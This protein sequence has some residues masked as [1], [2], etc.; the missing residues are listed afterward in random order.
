MP[1]DNPSDTS[2]SRVNDSSDQASSVP[3]DFESQERF[4]YILPLLKNASEY[5]VPQNFT[6]TVMG[7]LAAPKRLNPLARMRERFGNINIRVWTDVADA[8]ECALCFFLAGF[9]YFT[10]SIVLVLGLKPLET[11]APL[12]TWIIIQPQLSLLNAIGFMALGFILVKKSASA[13][14]IAQAGTIIYIGFTV[15]NGIG[16]Q[17]TP[18]NPFT[19]VGLLCFVGGALM[20][21]VF[22]LVILQKFQIKWT[23]RRVKFNH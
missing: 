17:R 9:F 15:F 10:L 12:A 21:G 6:A 5:P 20:L 23:D 13:V 22:L 19:T 8:T 11:Q 14:R 18:G 3:D 16:I 7:R 4:K 2:P 1:S